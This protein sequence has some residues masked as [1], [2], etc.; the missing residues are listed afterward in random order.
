MHNYLIIIYNWIWLI[1][2]IAASYS[3]I[4][5]S[6]YQIFVKYFIDLLLSHFTIN[7]REEKK[8]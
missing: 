7:K 4:E 6:Y 5:V 3:S 8:N 1:K 2:K